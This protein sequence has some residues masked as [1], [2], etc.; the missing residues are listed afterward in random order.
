M[1]C[2]KQDIKDSIKKTRHLS[3]EFCKYL[4]TVNGSSMHG[5]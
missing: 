3:D 2:V 4:D 1:F 5:C